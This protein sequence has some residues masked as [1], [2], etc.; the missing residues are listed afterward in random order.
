MSSE[1]Y[2]RIF[3]DGVLSSFLIPFHSQTAYFAMLAFGGQDD[4]TLYTATAVAIAG[5]VVGHSINW[6]LGNAA[7][8]FIRAQNIAF[9]TESYPKIQPYFN[10]YGIYTLLLSWMPLFS[11][12]SFAGGLF[13]ASYKKLVL[14]LLLISQT[15]Y[16]LHN[17]TH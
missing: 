10:R 3:N 2:L 16:Y 11:V 5:G 15:A 4:A 7:M 8:R 13:A 14:P 12:F 9:W 6:L 17:M 1:L